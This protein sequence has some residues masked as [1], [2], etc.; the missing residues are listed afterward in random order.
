MKNLY[1]GVAFIALLW[2]GQAAAQDMS[3]PAGTA[4]ASE[5]H[6]SGT[7]QEPDSSA[8]IVVTAQ[9]RSERLVDVP[10][11]ISTVSTEQIELAG[12][13]SLMSLNKLVPGVYMSKPVY[14]LSPTVRGVGS[15]LSL[16][17]E[18]AVAVYIDGVYQPSQASNVFDLA[19]ISGVE[20]VKGPQGTLFG[21]NATGG[22]ILVKTLDPS[23]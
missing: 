1:A 23:N 11:S 4:A 12:Q 16:S 15:T 18:S 10:I 6:S 7:A 21:R 22:A 5:R 3:A 19:S 13:D 9:R 2:T 17:N 20:V 14:F 8:D